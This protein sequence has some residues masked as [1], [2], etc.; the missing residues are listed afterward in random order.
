MSMTDDSWILNTACKSGILRVTLLSMFC[1]VALAGVAAGAGAMSGMRE[2]LNQADD[3]AA[4][5]VYTNAAQ[6]ISVRAGGKF[7][8]RLASNPTTGYQWRLDELPDPAPVRLALHRYEEPAARR[9]GAGGHEYWEFDA[10]TAGAVMLH[11]A[12]LR[13][14]EPDKIHTQCVFRVEVAP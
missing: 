4:V 7:A 6:A 10:V 9:L 2:K 12:Y 3:A 13:P 1:G 14:W 5:P 8:V 11:L